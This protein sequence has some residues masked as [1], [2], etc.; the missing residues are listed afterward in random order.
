MHCTHYCTSQAT[1]NPNAS[2]PPHFLSCIQEIRAREG[3]IFEP[4]E[5]GVTEGR[6]LQRR[7]R[8]ASSLP[9]NSEIQG[10]TG[11]QS[12]DTS[13]EVVDY[14][15]L[16]PTLTSVLKHSSIQSPDYR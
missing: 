11:N 4:L 8:R 3:R 6:T 7:A 13:P 2:R 14:K 12:T 15:T 5:V 16:D 1:Q 9:L 10:Q